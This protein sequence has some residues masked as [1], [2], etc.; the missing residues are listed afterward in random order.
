MA[1]G[2]EDEAPPVAAGPSRVVMAAVVVGMFVVGIAAGVGGSMFLGGE[3]AAAAEG[4][5]PVEGEGGE[6]AAPAHGE[7]AAE[8]EPGHRDTPSA[9]VSANGRLV[10]TLGSFTINLRGGG[11]G[12]LLRT[13]VQVELDAKD[14]KLVETNLPKLRDAVI[15]LVSDYAYPDLEGVDGKTALRDEL[16]ARLD[17]AVGGGH[18]KRVYFTEFVVQ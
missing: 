5:T 10:E 4:E 1:K 17:S 2:K 18:V 6:A 3:H 7:A 14:Q 15:T 8:P 13:E 11:G 9:S 16:L 12:R